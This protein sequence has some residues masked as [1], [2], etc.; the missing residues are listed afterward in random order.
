MKYIMLVKKLVITAAAGALMLGS[1]AGAFASHHS[2]SH[3]FN[4]NKVAVV[5]TT[6]TVSNEVFT[7]SNTGLNETSSTDGGNSTGDAKSGKAFK[8]GESG[9]VTGGAATSGGNTTAVVTG[10]A[11]AT[12][13]VSTT[14]GTTTVSF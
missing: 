14:V 4:G 9:D 12:S 13:T 5:T 10:D 1:A 11:S 7:A 6:S 2:V 8:G 3:S